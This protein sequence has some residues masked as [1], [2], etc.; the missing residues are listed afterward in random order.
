[1]KKQIQVICNSIMII[2]GITLIILGL[3]GQRVSA[4]TTRGCGVTPPCGSFIIQT[5]LCRNSTDCCGR[6]IGK[7]CDHESG[8]C[9]DDSSWAVYEDCFSYNCSC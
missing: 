3:T 8:P 4:D 6:Q 1:M 7:G 9:V 2:M 5:R